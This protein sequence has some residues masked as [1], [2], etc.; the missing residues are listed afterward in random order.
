MGGGRGDRSGQN[1]IVS[2]RREY[3]QIIISRK[4]IN[5]AF[6]QNS[7]GFVNIRAI[8]SFLSTDIAIHEGRL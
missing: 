6:E 4:S 8:L 7:L 5:S 3:R 1:E 2:R